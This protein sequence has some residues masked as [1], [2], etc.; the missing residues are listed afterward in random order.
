[1][2]KYTLNACPKPFQIIRSVYFS[3]RKSIHYNFQFWNYYYLLL[4]MEYLCVCIFFFLQKMI[5]FNYQKINVVHYSP[6]Y[7]ILYFL[8]I[9]IKIIFTVLISYNSNIRVCYG[10][11]S[12]FTTNQIIEFRTGKQYNNISYILWPLSMQD[13]VDRLLSKQFLKEFSNHLILIHFLQCLT[14]IS[15]FHNDSKFV[16]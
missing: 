8:F 13:I 12:F 14:T 6:F 10:K 2:Q 3:W 7:N 4:F 11:C 1:M 16:F 5:N 9:K 15:I